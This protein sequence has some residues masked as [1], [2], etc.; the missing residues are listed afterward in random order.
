MALTSEQASHALRDLEAVSQRSGQLYRYQRTAPMLV[1]WGVLWFIGFGATQL[2]PAFAQWLWLALDIVGVLGCIY[3]GRRAKD[4]A[5]PNTSW[6]W[7]GSILTIIVFCVLVLKILPPSASSQVGA[8]F[9]LV[10]ALFY[11]LAGLWIGARLA[12]IGVA[13]AALTVFGYIMLPVYFAV[14]MAAVGGGALVL[15]GLWL[16][17]A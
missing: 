16:R 5:S 14:W 1:M 10:V 4:D 8:L 6:R 3:L 9:A 17:T 11:V 12:I 2:S 15:G 13:L 7:L